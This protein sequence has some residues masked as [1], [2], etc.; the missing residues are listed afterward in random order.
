MLLSYPELKEIFNTNLNLLNEIIKERKDG[1]GALIVGE[2]LILLTKDR[3]FLEEKN[4]IDANL[5]EIKGQIAS[6]GEVKGLAR[7]IHN[8]TKEMMEVKPGEIIITHMTT[9]CH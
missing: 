4:K 5:M 1:F 2:Q 6:M 7:V 3:Y 8:I 9:Q